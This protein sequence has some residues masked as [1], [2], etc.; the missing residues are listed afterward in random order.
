MGVPSS[1]KLDTSTGKMEKNRIRS[2]TGD[3]DEEGLS[4]LSTMKSSSG[5]RFYGFLEEFLTYFDWNN[6]ISLIEKKIRCLND[7]KMLEFKK[8]YG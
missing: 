7:I 5:C 2:M 1:D 4:L 6:Q 8:L 3:Q